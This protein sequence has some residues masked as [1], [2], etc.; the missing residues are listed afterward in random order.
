MIDEP[1]P[2]GGGR[3]DGG[4]RP[5]GGARPAGGGHER[6]ASAPSGAAWGRGW[7]GEPGRLREMF[8]RRAD[9]VRPAA[10]AAM[11]AV[12][13]G[14]PDWIGADVERRSLRRAERRAG[15]PRRWARRWA[16]G[17]TA[18]WSAVA[19]AAP[20]VA[21]AEQHASW[22]ARGVAAALRAGLAGWEMATLRRDGEALPVPTAL[23]PRPWQRRGSGGGRPPAAGGGR[24][25]GAGGAG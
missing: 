16:A 13:P 17:R 8:D 5:E 25:P 23:A 2:E 22:L 20:I 10:Q 21:V 9:G 14:L 6:A 7:A 18:G 11:A 1:V 12:R 4:S 15:R 19:A 3:P 24:A